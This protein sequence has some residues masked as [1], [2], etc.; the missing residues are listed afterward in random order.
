MK[1]MAPGMEKLSELL[2]KRAGSSKEL[3]KMMKKKK[4]LHIPMKACK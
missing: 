1:S 3:V 2:A 4:G